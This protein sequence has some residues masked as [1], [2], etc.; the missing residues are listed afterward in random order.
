MVSLQIE[1]IKDR[2]A[3]LITTP[4]SYI[5]NNIKRTGEYNL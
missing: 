5:S 3:V 2:D 1:E 4:F